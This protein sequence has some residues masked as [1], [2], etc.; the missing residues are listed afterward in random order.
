LPADFP[1][2]DLPARV[3]VDLGKV[4]KPRDPS[5]PSRSFA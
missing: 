5:F 1:Q 4:D 2:I 3:K